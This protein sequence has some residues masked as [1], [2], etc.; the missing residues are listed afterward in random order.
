MARQHFDSYGCDSDNL[1]MNASLYF[2]QFKSWHLLKLKLCREKILP[3]IEM[4]GTKRR[5]VRGD[6]R[7]G[8]TDKPLPG[9]NIPGS[10]RKPIS[11]FLFGARAKLAG[12]NGEQSPVSTFQ[13]GA[14]LR[15][16]ERSPMDHVP[17][18]GISPLLTAVCPYSA[19]FSFIIDIF[20]NNAVRKA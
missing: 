5:A 20:I 7:G 13:H 17:P 4:S 6:C 9:E 3:L 14:T 16:K 2:D 1:G 18:S 15:S 19:G 12:L 11:S 8:L 10:T